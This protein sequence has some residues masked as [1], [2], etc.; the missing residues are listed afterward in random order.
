[1]PNGKPSTFV[2]SFFAES[3]QVAMQRAR[4][5]LGT[6]ALL[7]NSRDAPPEARHL[8]AF[9]VVFAT[10]TEAVEQYSAPVTP[11]APA[12]VAVPAAA[13]IPFAQPATSISSVSKEP[14]LSTGTETLRRRLETLLNR[15]TPLAAG[16]RNQNSVIAKTLIEA[17]LEPSFAREVESA[18]RQ[19]VARR[20]VLRI[21]SP[22]PAGTPDDQALLLEAAAEISAHFEVAPEIGRV[23]ALVGP[24]GSGKTTTI[25]KLALTQGLACGRAVCLIS[26]GTQ[27]IGGAEQLRAYAAVLGATFQSVEATEELAQAIESAPPA[28]LV[29]IDTPGQ[30]AA[31]L[32][33]LGGDLATFLSSRQDID[34]HLVLTASMRIEDLHNAAALYDPFRPAKLIFTRLDET[35]SLAAVFSVAARRNCPISFLSTGQ[36]I[37]EDLE[38]ATKHKIVQSLVREL[39]LAAEAAA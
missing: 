23:T 16:Q 38:P 21:G 27:K 11:P 17:G 25:V 5:E 4:A 13:P 22:R 31:L 37:P 32:R 3:I 14:S 28:A 6:D 26:T 33:D 1:M 7:L 24:P 10:C 30:S 35:S 12:P 18:S 39:P 15:M 36:S 20:S 9:E 29:L 8:G 19:R 2:K 34:T